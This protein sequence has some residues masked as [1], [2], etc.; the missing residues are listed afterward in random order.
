MDFDDWLVYKD[1]E[2]Y[3]YGRKGMKWGKTIFGGV[4]NPKSLTYDPYYGREQSSLSPSHIKPTQ[5]IYPSF[6]GSEY[7]INKNSTK[8]IKGTKGS[9]GSGVRGNIINDSKNFGGWVFDKARQLGEESAR[10]H[11]TG[12]AID[13]NTYK[14]TSDMN[15]RVSDSPYIWSH[16]GMS[17]LEQNMA[18]QIDDGRKAYE[19]M[20][21][22][23]SIKNILNLAIQNAQYNIVSGI[24]NVLTKLGLDD[25]VDRWLSKWIGYSDWQSRNEATQYIIDYNAE[26]GPYDV[27]I[28]SWEGP[29]KYKNPGPGRSPYEPKKPSQR[30]RPNSSASDRL[31]PKLPGRENLW[32]QIIDTI[33][34]IGKTPRN[35]NVRKPKH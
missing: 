11:W 17:H 27:P 21:D 5:R 28:Y 24:N 2:L 7:A 10:K 13:F 23:G 25:E 29:Y 9:I 20:R 31:V 6:R 22:D 3:H 35:P 26:R 14:S 15:K 4:D 12:N 34:G 33:E 8:S 16:R 19:A 32:D 18:K 1:N 30:K